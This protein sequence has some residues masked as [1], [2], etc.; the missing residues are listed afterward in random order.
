[1]LLGCATSDNELQTDPDPS[2]SKSEEVYWHDQ[3]DEVQWF[4]AIGANDVTFIPEG[5]ATPV[6]WLQVCVH[7]LCDEQN[8]VVQWFNGMGANDAKFIPEGDAVEEIFQECLRLKPLSKDKA[9]IYKT[10]LADRISEIQVIT[11][12]TPRSRV[13]QILSQNGGTST[14]SA[15]IYSHAD[16]YMLKV[17][18]EFESTSNSDG[19]FDFNDNDKVKATSLPYLGLYIAD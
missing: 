15:A 9:A 4:N 2:V 16:C 3:E 7:K 10:W 14:P 11:P 5:N 8:N 12:G 1:M 17:R 19:R 18:I 13:N 6:Y